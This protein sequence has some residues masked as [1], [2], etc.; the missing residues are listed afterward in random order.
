MAKISDNN[1][2]KRLSSQYRLV[3]TNDDTYEEVVTFKL[4]RLSVYVGL[5]TVFVLLV[6]FTIALIVFTPL[7]YYIPG[8]GSRQSR[9]EL[10][11][12]KIRTDSLEQAIH[13]KDQYLQGLQHI[14]NGPAASSQRDTTAIV[15]PRQEITTD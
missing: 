1:S 13:Y 10:Q 6:S 4:S 11:L 14:L 7:K 5:S 2:L 3:V 8:Y 9:S 15:V 12:L